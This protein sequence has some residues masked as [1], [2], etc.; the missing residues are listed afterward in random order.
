MAEEL[1]QSDS[2]QPEVAV[3][4][5]Q[6]TN[7]TGKPS[8]PVNTSTMTDS[9]SRDYYNKTQAL[10]Q[11]RRSFEAE[12]QAW[13]QKQGNQP[14]SHAPAYGQPNYTPPQTQYYGQA[15][16][17]MPLNPNNPDVFKG[18]VDQFGYDGA[19]TMLQT[20]NSI[21]QPVQQQLA[22]AQQQL[23]QTQYSTLRHELN[24]KGRDLF[25]EAWNSRANQVLEKVTQYGCPLEEAW[26]IV[27]FGNEKQAGMDA[28]YKAQE[29]KTSA[30][31][32]SGTVAP[33]KSGSMSVNSLDDAVGLALQ[34]H[35]MS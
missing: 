8:E 33:V 23:A 14:A 7:A 32:N 6:G 29:I 21:T 26:A 5:D 2:S 1:N 34:E 3:S 19:N 25:G 16:Q 15:P 31:V 35:G 24:S 17:G 20:F 4:G 11:D 10:A 27:N 9:Q 13:Y 28:A 18:L 22:L 30:N 12:K